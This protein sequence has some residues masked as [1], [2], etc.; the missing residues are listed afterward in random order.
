MLHQIRHRGPDGEGEYAEEGVALGHA[1]LAII[2][3]TDGGRQ[4][5]ASEV[6][7]LQLLHNGEIFN[8]VELRRDLQALGHRFRS[9]TD[10]E[11]VLHAYAQWGDDCVERFNGMWAFALWDSDRRRLFCSRDR[12]GIKPFAYRWD[13]SRLVFASEPQAI[14]ADPRTR[15]EPNLA[16]VADFLEQG[17]T[18]HR[19]ETFFAGIDQLLP[20]H[21][22]I[23]DEHGLH[24]GPWWRLEPADVPTD[25]IG[26]FREMFVDSVRLRLRSDVPLGTALS[27]GLDS[28]AVA[29]AIDY[30]LR[31]E[32][33]GARAVGE[34]Q[35][36]FTVYFDDEGHDER[37]Y[38]DAVGRTIRSRPH[39]ITF[40]DRQLLE[41]LPSV[42]RSHGEPFGSTSIVAQWFVMRAAATAG[43]T[44]MLDGQGGDEILAGY[45]PATRAY[46]H[47]DLLA[48][49][50][51]PTLA[52]EL[53][54]A[55]E[56]PFAAARSLATPF[57][58]N[59]ARWALRG[60]RDGA[61]NLRG[62]ALPH[63]TP[64]IELPAAKFPDRLRTQY[65]RILSRY[66]LPE[67]LRYEDRN[68][69]AHS[70]EGRVPF[71]DHRLVELAYGL[72]AEQL[73]EGGLTKRVLREA[74]HDLLPPEVR[75]RRDKLGFVTPERRFMNGALGQHARRVFGERRSRD[76]GLV[77][78]DET[79]RWIAAGKT[80][81]FALWRALSV[82]LWARTFL[83]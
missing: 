82:E 44:V 9:E 46:R 19:G 6:G 14:L 58:P 53:A 49:G 38:A 77:D 63:S 7:S 50:R 42:V 65:H 18:D 1:R 67:L 31:T 40:D 34:R 79:L 62:R 57:L 17:Y 33:E 30:L 25:P 78:V 73:V 74:L 66:G 64:A 51:L 43:L 41:I 16:A 2:D 71:L 81:S 70:L 45:Q 48:A 75:D 26:T 10:T 54:A 61:K 4:P 60:R 11:V 37:P 5:F 80:G 32:V 24:V 15:A 76:R 21:N 52:R 8:Y 22:L 23:V 69:M 83:D 35:E 68:T 13:G 27:G 56:R 72:P 59:R 20:G 3:L 12:F 28:S 55:G 47:A 29:V 39:P 36:T